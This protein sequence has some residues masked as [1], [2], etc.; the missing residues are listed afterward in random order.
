[1]VGTSLFPIDYPANSDATMVAVFE[2][3]DDKR[4]DYMSALPVGTLWHARGIIDAYLVGVGI[5]LRLFLCRNF[6]ST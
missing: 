6:R 1:M 4:A 3:T 2:F 5:P